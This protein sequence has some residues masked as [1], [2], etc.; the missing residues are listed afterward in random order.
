MACERG[1]V[2]EKELYRHRRA[3]AHEKVRPVSKVLP[4]G[5][6]I[7]LPCSSA[8][9]RRRDQLRGVHRGSLVLVL[10]SRPDD[11]P[12]AHRVRDILTRTA[13]QEN[14]VPKRVVEHRVGDQPTRVDG[15]PCSVVLADGLALPALQVVG[16][17]YFAEELL[18]VQRLD[19]ASM[20]LVVICE[21]VV[22]EEG[23]VQVRGDPE[24]D[25]TRARRAR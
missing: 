23:R 6:A 20:V 1:R 15:F 18:S 5:L 9:V 13:S 19:V 7:T 17:T 22:E 16:C 10:L 14:R 21:L 11:A 12:L 3:V 4:A 25:L 24:E 8:P 2:S